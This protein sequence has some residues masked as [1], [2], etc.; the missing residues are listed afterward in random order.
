[1][2]DRNGRNTDARKLAATP[3]QSSTRD[4]GD[5]HDRDYSGFTNLLYTFEYRCQDGTRPA[6]DMDL[7]KGRLEVEQVE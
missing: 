2:T 7:T 4:R 5:D 1:M 3:A 6:L